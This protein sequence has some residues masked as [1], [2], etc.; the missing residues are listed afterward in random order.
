MPK[1]EVKDLTVEYGERADKTVA[2][3]HVSFS[4]NSGEFVTIIGSSG[5]GKS[6]LLSV[7]EGLRAPTSGAALI[8]GVEIDGPGPE[9]SVVF[10]HYSLFPWLTARE[11]VAFGI[12]QSHRSWS[13]AQC[14][15]RADEVLGKVGL[16]GFERKFP[17]QLSGGM[18]QRVAIARSLA[19]DASILL[20]DEPFGAIDAKNRTLLQD[21]LL[22]IWEGDT[23]DQKKTVVFVTHDID[24]AILLAD[25]VVLL[26]SHPG[27][28]FEEYRVP[29]SRPR[30]RESLISSPEYVAL[31]AKIY[32]A[33]Y[34]K[35]LD[36]SSLEEAAL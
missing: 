4:I 12:K 20:M 24:E 23:E 32:H 16:S 22:N 13:K 14:R 11:N 15:K 26:S 35:T 18:Q 2:L 19:S 27:E 31:R 25:K 3:S 30:A 33:L 17:G 29:F 21:F 5:C 6:T 9:R 34:S 28:V 7:L 8:D 1:I 36:A 10:Q